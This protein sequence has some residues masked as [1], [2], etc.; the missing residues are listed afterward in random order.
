MHKLLLIILTI[1]PSISYCQH[2][3]IKASHLCNI[4]RNSSDLYKT[5]DDIQTIPIDYKDCYFSDT[6]KSILLPLLSRDYF[7][8]YQYKV[9][10]DEEYTRSAVLNYLK[11]RHLR[12]YYDSII[13]DSNLYQAYSDSAKSEA[14]TKLSLE[15]KR[16][17]WIQNSLIKLITNIKWS[18]S[19][20]LL[21]NNWVDD[22]KSITSSVFKPLISFHCP[23]AI[24]MYNSLINK[25]IQ[26]QK[27]DFLLKIKHEIFNYHKYGSYCL[28]LY[29][30]LLH[31]D[32]LYYDYEI[33]SSDTLGPQ[34]KIP[35]NYNLLS[36]DLN[37]KEEFITSDNYKFAQ[38]KD[39]IFDQS[40][41][42]RMYSEIRLSL[43]GKQ[44]VRFADSFEQQLQ[45]K[46]E[47]MQRQELYWKQNMPYY[48]KE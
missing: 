38:L 32:A 41:N 10:W 5:I 7:F 15:F 18:E 46:K 2:D 12:N 42:K 14:L 6:L 44:I 36:A 47:Y 13:N 20:I 37:P 25:A 48:K 21:Y 4:L 24:Q 30:Q 27:I 19:Y 39:S 45:Q 17:P 31:C 16:K 40:N 34:H 22:G 9:T 43:L 1:F 33:Y 26:L 35:F 8:E 23:E 3:T 29:I 28:D 11:N